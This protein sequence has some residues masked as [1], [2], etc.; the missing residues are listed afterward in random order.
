MTNRIVK[1]LGW[2]T[3]T[4]KITAILDGITVFSGDVNLA[5]MTKDNESGQ[6][7]PTL[8]TFEIPMDFAGTKHMAIA[9]Q[10]APVRFGQVVANYTE[11][12]MGEIVY[13]T[14]ADVYADIAEFDGAGVCDPRSN[15]TIDGVKCEAD[16]LVGLGTWHWT[17]EPGS[18][19]E[20]DLTITTPG[21]EE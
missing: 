1:I 10:K 19:F 15:V 7:A 4:A 3:G 21:V 20:H 12:Q 13:S 14:G 11:V 8:F 9:I 2:G 16:R 18:K 17:V 6:T 5:E